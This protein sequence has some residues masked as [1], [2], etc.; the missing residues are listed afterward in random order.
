LPKPRAKIR[1]VA[2]FE[3]LYRRKQMTPDF[4]ELQTQTEHLVFIYDN[5][6]RGLPLHAEYLSEAK[7]LGSA[8][9]L[10]NNWQLM[11][12]PSGEVPILLSGSHLNTE[13][14]PNFHNVKGEV[15][16]LTLHQLIRLDAMHDNTRLFE[17]EQKYC[18]LEDQES[19]FKID[20]STGKKPPLARQCHVYVGIPQ[21]W[22]HCML[23]FAT[24]LHTGTRTFWNWY[25]NQT[26]RQKKMN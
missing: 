4:A 10:E 1:D 26:N 22:E 7:Y 2:L 8:R 6:K 24:K 18:I 20:P 11:V 3:E 23:H 21:V 15:Y 5:Y 12:T 13:D 17:R 19:P 16:A 9:T 14:K 25:G